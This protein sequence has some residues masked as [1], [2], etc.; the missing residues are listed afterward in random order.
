MGNKVAAWLMGV[1]AVVV[2]M[3]LALV[4]MGV[5][6]MVGIGFLMS[7]GVLLAAFWIHF[8][9]TW[10]ARDQEKIAE[11]NRKITEQ[12][13][14]IQTVF[15][16]RDEASRNLNAARDSL[17][18]A[19]ANNNLLAQ[20][21]ASQ[22]VIIR[23][24]NAILQEK[25]ID[26]TA[27]NI[28]PVGGSERTLA[29]ASVARGNPVPPPGLSASQRAQVVPRSS[30]RTGRS[31]HVPEGAPVHHA[32]AGN[33]GLL[34]GVMLGSMLHSDPAPAPTRPEP[35]CSPRDSGYDSPRDSGYDGGSSGGSDSSS[36]SS[37]D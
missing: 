12:Q 16:E 5:G 27:A 11:Q 15:Y 2:I 23:R 34:T 3:V 25:G 1:T 24:L 21:N 14:T 4:P 33:D 31:S 35:T 28:P 30:T 26:I 29:S 37:C 9:A 7:V 10:S 17:R 19:D 20:E 6:V 32:S 22:K 36:P 13:R 8:Q 18:A